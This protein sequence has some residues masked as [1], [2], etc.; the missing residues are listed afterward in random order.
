M[1]PNSRPS[2]S[3][4]TELIYHAAAEA[5]WER[6]TE[7]DYEPDGYRAE[8]FVHCSSADQLP[9]VLERFYRGRTDLRVLTIDPAAVTHRVVWEDLYDAGEEFPH[10][11][12]PVELTAVRSVISLPCRADGGFVWA[13]PGMDGA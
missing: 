11:Y 6:R 7:T 4:V 2:I 13:P 5:D 9:G 3:K 10:I 12:G 1:W 8:G